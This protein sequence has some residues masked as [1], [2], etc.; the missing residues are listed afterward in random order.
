[1]PDL[2]A[3]L[4]M[5]LIMPSQAQKHVTHNEALVILDALV[6]TGVEVFDASAPP[7]NPAEGALYVLGGSPTGEWAGQAGMLALRQGTGWRFLAPQAGWRAWDL[8][9]GALM[10]FDGSA[11][12]PL[13]PDFNNLTGLGIG[14]S[15]DAVNVLA[16]A[17]EA[18][19]FSHAGAGHQIKV[20]KASAAETASLLFQSNWTGHA[21]MGLAGDTGFSIKVSPDGGTW[22]DA[23][24][25]DP[26]SGHASGAAIQQSA[27]DTTAGR[28]MRT[29]WGYGPGNL[30]GAVTE[31]GGTPTGAVIE[32][33]S[34]GNGDYVRLAD[35]TQ[36][37]WIR[38]DL[39]YDSGQRL[40][41]GWTFPMA[42]VATGFPAISVNLENE[43]GATPGPSQLHGPY[44]RQGSTPDTATCSLR[45]YRSDG[46]PDFASGDSLP[47]Q[48]MAIGRWF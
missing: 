9:N 13:V 31:A 30:L 24:A 34:T 32:R 47:V 15:A 3:R 38:A 36:I 11:W 42:F 7:A 23:L 28:L 46:A 12:G 27:T 18:S 41:F 45:L 29:D 26:T 16:L 4:N 8:G 43:F 21:E 14:A 44:A 5:P 35:G 19:L 17:G 48:A 39:T 2:S 37:C 22:T 10:V 33:G 1:M 6:Q 20:N 40:I 25:F